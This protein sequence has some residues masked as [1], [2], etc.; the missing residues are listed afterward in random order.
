M[1]LQVDEYAGAVAK[2]ISEFAPTVGGALGVSG[3]VATVV[4]SKKARHTGEEE[5]T[6]ISR[7]FQRLSICLM[8]G[9]A[10]LFNNRCPPETATGD[11][12]EW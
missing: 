9:N 10:A 8:R 1:N 12:I 3:L 7:L 5:A 11:E 4:H 6:T 2:G